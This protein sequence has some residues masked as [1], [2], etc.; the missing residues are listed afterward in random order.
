MYHNGH[1]NPHFRNLTVRPISSNSYADHN[2]AITVLVVRPIKAH[3]QRAFHR[4]P[5]SDIILA[6]RPI[7]PVTSHFNTT[8]STLSSWY[9][10]ILLIAFPT[11][12]HPSASFSRSPAAIFTLHRYI[13]WAAAEVTMPTPPFS[14]DRRD[15]LTE[16]SSLFSQKKSKDASSQRNKLNLGL[17]TACDSVTTISTFNSRDDASTKDQ[18]VGNRPRRPE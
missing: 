18:A 11:L 16:I 5:S 2:F 3:H 6:P 10:H 8:M 4:L 12:S 15:W 9:R 13:D 17:P 7:R 14:Q 1:M